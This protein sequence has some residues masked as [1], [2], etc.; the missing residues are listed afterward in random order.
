MT[1]GEVGKNLSLA[2]C[3]HRLGFGIDAL[4]ERWEVGTL[5]SGDSNEQSPNDQHQAD[6]DHEADRQEAFV[7]SFA[8]NV[9][10]AHHHAAPTSRSVGLTRQ[11]V[12]RQAE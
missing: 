2:E 6:R 9:A 5:V 4:D 8:G 11:G 3:L 12:T 7:E 1:G 10:H